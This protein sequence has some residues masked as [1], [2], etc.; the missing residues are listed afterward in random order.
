[1]TTDT[2]TQIKTT[3]KESRRR[4]P[5]TRKTGGGHT[6]GRASKKEPYREAP[7]KKAS[8]IGQN[9]IRVIPLGGVEEV[10]KNMTVV[11]QGDDILV[12]DAGISFS[13]DDDTPGVDYVIP[14]TSYLEDRKDL[15]RAVFITHGHLDHIGGIPFILPKLGNPTI[16]T[17]ELTSIMIKKRYEE[18]PYLKQ[19]RIEIVELGKKIR[20]GNIYVYAFR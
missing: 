16:Y 17:R 18:F 5:A 6:Q 2:N 14:D 7:R 15:I 3:R 13:S 9:V 8:E 10:G 4:R 11:E 1:M 12:F 19:P 20:V